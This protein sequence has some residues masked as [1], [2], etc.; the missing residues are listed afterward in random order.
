MCCGDHTNLPCGGAKVDSLWQC[1]SWVSFLSYWGGSGAL[2]LESF[3]SKRRMKTRYEFVSLI[4]VACNADGKLDGGR[5]WTTQFCREVISVKTRFT[6]VNSVLPTHQKSLGHLLRQVCRPYRALLWLQHKL[7]P[8]TR[9]NQ[10]KE[11]EADCFQLFK[12]R[13]HMNMKTRRK[14]KYYISLCSPSQI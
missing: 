9:K 5:S 4:I 8:W 3:R 1:W 13:N 6:K 14:T 7:F 11:C 12:V 10:D 2:D